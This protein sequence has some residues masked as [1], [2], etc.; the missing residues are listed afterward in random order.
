MPRLGSSTVY[1]VMSAS[2]TVGTATTT[3]GQRQPA[4]GPAGNAPGQRCNMAQAAWP[5]VQ[6]QGLLCQVDA[7][8]QLR[9]ACHGPKLEC[10]SSVCQLGEGRLAHELH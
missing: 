5:C 1:Q 2:S 4:D 8:L 9:L 6:A 10:Q 3:N 7:T